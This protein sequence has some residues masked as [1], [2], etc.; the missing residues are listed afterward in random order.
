[1]SKS[2]ELFF[3]TV[4]ALC[5]DGKVQEVSQHFSY[6]LP[7][8]AQD[9]LLVFGSAEMLAE[10]L[11]IFHRCM[12]RLEIKRLVPTI[13]RDGLPHDG[14]S[15]VIVQWAHMRAD[16]ICVKT[17]QVRYLLRQ[18]ADNITPRIEMID[19][20]SEQQVDASAEQCQVLFA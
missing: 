9:D 15:T 3:R 1:M 14:Y 16:G 13:V 19:D 11:A 7:V 20:L 10:G 18:D 4:G 12:A 17:S 2:L 6:P 5:L 8:S